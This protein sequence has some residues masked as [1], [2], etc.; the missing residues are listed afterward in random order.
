[1]P[2]R[3]LESIVGDV[4]DGVDRFYEEKARPRVSS[5]AVVTVATVDKKGV[6]IRKPYKD[7][8]GSEAAVPHPDKPGKKKMATVISPVKLIK[9]GAPLA[10]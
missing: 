7:E 8:A 5:E 3:C 10:R 6:I 9:R 1:M 4:C 2:I